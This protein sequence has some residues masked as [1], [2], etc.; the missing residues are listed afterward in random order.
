MKYHSLTPFFP[1]L[2]SLSNKEWDLGVREF[3]DIEKSFENDR[4][5]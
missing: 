4:N 5:F 3:F 2:S 1:S